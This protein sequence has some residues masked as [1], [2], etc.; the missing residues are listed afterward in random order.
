MNKPT[1]EMRMTLLNSETTRKALDPKH[2]VTYE[3]SQSLNAIDGLGRLYDALSQTRHA[4]NPK[5]T[6]EAA[7]MRYDKQYTEAMAKANDLAEGAAR[8]LDAL[9]LRSGRAHCTRPASVTPSRAITKS[10]H[11]CAA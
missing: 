11:P 1:N 4:V 2:A 6:V 7:A 9:A 10:A 8:K 3:I 5:E